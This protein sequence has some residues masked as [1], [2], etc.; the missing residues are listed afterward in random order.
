MQMW[1]R[2]AEK[3]FLTWTVKKCQTD[4]KTIQ[5]NSIEYGDEK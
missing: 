1:K 3:S 5:N 4:C 2:E